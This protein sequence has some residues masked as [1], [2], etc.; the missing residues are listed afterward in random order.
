MSESDKVFTGKT[1]LITG[2]ARGIG[3]ATARLASSLGAKVIL[4]GRTASKSLQDLAAELNADWIANDVG[5]K[6]AV[7]QNVKDV[8]AKTGKID[9]LIISAGIAPAEPFLEATDEHWLE[10]YRTNVLGVVNFCQAVIPHM[11]E[12]GYGRIVNVASIR[13]HATG[14]SSRVSAY[15]ASKAAVINLTSSL[16]KEFAPN[17]AVNAVSPGFT[18]TDIT[19]NWVD[20]TWEKAKSS[21]LGRIGQP[22]EIAEAIVF[23]ASDK[24]RFITGQTLIVDG[25]YISAGK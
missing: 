20:A 25:G 9:V 1:V 11:Q 6:N 22:E 4:H 18:E 23:L 17:I 5:D 21:L 13:G 12:Q 24:A 10:V 8:I 19:E 16:A 15:S 7:Q 3:A 2:S 14:P